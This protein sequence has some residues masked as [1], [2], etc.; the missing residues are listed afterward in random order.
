MCGSTCNGL[1]LAHSRATARILT[2]Q[3]VGWL[4]SIGC[5]LRPLRGEYTEERII[6]ITTA[7][8]ALC[9]PVACSQ[10]AL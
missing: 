5:V 6:A 3:T 4:Q 10:E 8:E 7:L 2:L 9:E 1:L